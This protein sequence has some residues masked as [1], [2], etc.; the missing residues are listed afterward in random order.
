MVC[1]Q[2][3]S[4][5]FSLYPINTKPFLFQCS[6]IVVS[7]G[8]H[9]ISLTTAVCHCHV[10]PRIDPVPNAPVPDTAAPRHHTL[11]V[12]CAIKTVIIILRHAVY[13]V[14]SCPGS[15]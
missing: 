11:C 1:G 7:V 12:T 8:I 15:V 13:G 2:L 3:V 10:A 9:Y 6:P 5:A 4:A 14:D